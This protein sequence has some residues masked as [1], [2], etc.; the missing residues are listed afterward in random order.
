MCYTYSREK[1][2]IRI[3]MITNPDEWEK[4]NCRVIS[5][6]KRRVRCLKNYSPL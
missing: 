5:N 3:V 4:N 6:G 2:G 1:I